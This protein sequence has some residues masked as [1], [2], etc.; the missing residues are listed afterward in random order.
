M[1]RRGSLLVVDDNELNRDA[2]SRRLQQ[3]GYDVLVAADGKEALE[4]AGEQRRPP[5][6][7]R[8]R[9]AGSER[10]RCP[11]APSPNSLPDRIADRHGDGQIAWHRHRRS[12]EPRGQRLHHQAGRF[13]RRPRSDRDAPVPQS[14][15]GGPARERRALRARSAGRERRALG[16]EFDDQRGPLVGAV[17]SDAGV[18]A[19]GDR[20]RVS[21]NG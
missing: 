12:P 18:R 3:R 10:T 1:T 15:R 14:G 2:L 16:L 4:L 21:T 20:L 9:N 6:P 11:Y 19:V 13:R 17:E 7:A 8:R 5:R